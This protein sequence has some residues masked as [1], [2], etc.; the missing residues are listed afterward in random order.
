MLRGARVFALSLGL[1]GL[2]TAQDPPPIPVQIFPASNPWNWDISA[3]PVH[4][5]SDLYIAAIG[6]NTPI[7]EDYAFPYVLVDDT[8]DD[9]NVEFEDYP[10]ESD[11]G[12]TFGSPPGGAT[13]G[14]YPIPPGAP[15]E[16]GGAGDAHVLVV[17]TDDMLLYET[18]STSGGPPWTAACGAIFNLQTND[19]RPEGWTSGDAAGLPIL[20]GLIR[21]DEATG[22]G[23]INHAFR[24]TCSPTQNRHI[25]PARHH[26][27]QANI[28]LPPMGLRVRLK[29]SKDISDYDGAAGKVLAALKKHGMILA[30][31]GSDWYISTSLHSDWE[32]TNLI[33][34]REM[35]GSD[36][37]VVQTV[38]EN[39][40]PMMFAAQNGSGPAPPPNPVA[41]GGGGGGG[42]G[43]CGLEGLLVLMLF[44]S[45][46]RRVA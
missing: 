17:D 1:L 45:A 2:L 34:I 15:I 42:C 37:E 33:R 36:F 8:V 23:S 12:P 10:T 41:G 6:A 28:N 4:P 32:D 27:G 22:L 20:P 9:V 19:M 43:S 26:A 13:S 39:G 7:R 40:V 11:P 16:G 30:D 35:K 38:D 25:F 21:F 3:L 24:F 14:D 29:A 46:R 18:Y 5:G 31:N 44:R